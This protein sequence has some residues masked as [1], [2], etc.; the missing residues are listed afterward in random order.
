[1]RRSSQHNSQDQEQSRKDNTGPA[2]QLV[3]APAKEEHAKYFTD[4][5]SVGQSGL[6]GGGKRIGIQLCEK[7]I[8][9]ADDLRIVAV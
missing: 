9:V 5:E 4:E 1:M 2:T 6:D 3:D 8:H 7:G